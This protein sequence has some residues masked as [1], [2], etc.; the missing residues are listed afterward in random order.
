MITT[1]SVAHDSF[2]VERTYPVAP[3]RVFDAWASESAKA[4]WFAEDLDFF[5]APGAYS[6]EF[7][8]GGRERLDG[9]LTNGRAFGYEA[10]YQDI[11]NGERIVASYD[12]RID[13]QRTSVSLM[14]VE[15]T[16]APGGT[17]LVLTEQG[18]FL[19]GLDSNAQRVEGAT[20][21]LDKLRDHLTAQS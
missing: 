8:I 14:T 17:R 5:A 6:L 12:V 13:G 7:R 2:T 21:M 11:V 19:D 3:K 18:A 9:T 4:R 10:V 16:A 20:D 15:I 1:R